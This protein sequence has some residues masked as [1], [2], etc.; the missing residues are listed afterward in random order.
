MGGLST[1][2]LT[3]GQVRG[4]RSGTEHADLMLIIGRLFLGL[5]VGVVQTEATAAPAR[6]SS[7]PGFN[8]ARAGTFFIFIY[9]GAPLGKSINSG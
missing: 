7:Y 5:P 1:S 9:T 2:S 6:K 4:R 3:A 8:G